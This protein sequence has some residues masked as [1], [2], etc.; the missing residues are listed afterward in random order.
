M[1]AS[2]NLRI[3]VILL[4]C[5][6]SLLSVLTI[7]SISPA[8][9]LS[10]G[11]TISIALGVVALL[12]HSKFVTWK[13]LT[14]VL[15]SGLIVLLCLTS[16]QQS[17]TKGAARWLKLGPVQVQPSQLVIPIIVLASAQ[18]LQKGPKKLVRS[19]RSDRVT[20]V[21]TSMILSVP[22]LVFIQPNLSTSLLIILSVVAVYLFS[23]FPIRYLLGVGA[24]G[25]VVAIIAWFLVLQDYQKNRIFSF[26]D[27]TR[28][29]LGIGYN[30]RQ[31]QIAIGS[32]GMI[33]QGMWGGTQAQL[34]FLPEKHTDFA[35]AAY[36]E[37]FGFFGSTILISLYLL[38]LLILIYIGQ[39][40]RGIR[41]VYSLSYVSILFF[42]FT[43]NIGM[44]I[45]LLPVTGLPLPFF[46]TGGSS[47]LAFAIGIGLILSREQIRENKKTQ[48]EIRSL[49]C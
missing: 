7:Y 22:A 29:E 26:L 28:D 48:I 43:I 39:S 34:G 36:A 6:I 30:A 2:I 3:V 5:G 18:V 40:S 23:G 4:L 1:I 20:Q 16:I 27:P 45:G 42:F 47:L 33:G 31:S 10:H 41:R 46:S 8:Y 14:W 44:N 32:G 13:R 9:L 25:I 15:L 49:I 12:M 21:K 17:V 37:Q 11:V 38:L 19:L 35:F 24:V